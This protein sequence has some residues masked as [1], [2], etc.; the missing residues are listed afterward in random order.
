MTYTHMYV[1]DQVYMGLAASSSWEIDTACYI[2]E[3]PFD[4]M[5]PIKCMPRL[6]MNF[7]IRVTYT[8]V[9]CL[10][11]TGWGE[12][13]GKGWHAGSVQRKFDHHCNQIVLFAIVYSIQPG[14]SKLCMFRKCINWKMWPNSSWQYIVVEWQEVVMAT[15]EWVNGIPPRCAYKAMSRKLNELLVHLVAFPGCT[16]CT[17]G[18]CHLSLSSCSFSII[19]YIYW[20]H[21]VTMAMNQPFLM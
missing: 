5:S 18:I 17:V 7:F 19:R 3:Y 15:H 9:P 10:S 11:W 12:L 13:T 16:Q 2:I 8:M 14:F 1:F 20:V 4:A 21:W 6:L